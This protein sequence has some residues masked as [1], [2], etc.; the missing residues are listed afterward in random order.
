MPFLFQYRVRDGYADE[1]DKPHNVSYYPR[2][3]V[4]FVAFDC[5]FFLYLDSLFLIFSL[6]MRSLFFSAAHRYL[7]ANLIRTD[8]TLP[9]L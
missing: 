8:Y 9:P 2:F 5:L 4:P 7:L 3:P 1:Q 6:L